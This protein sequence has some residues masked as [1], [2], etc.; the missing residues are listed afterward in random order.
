M[1]GKVIPI[2]KR[3]EHQKLADFL[4]SQQG[5]TMLKAHGLRRALGF[6][7]QR[8]N[9]KLPGYSIDIHHRG[10]KGIGTPIG[11]MRV[12]DGT[13]SVMHHLPNGRET[14]ELKQLAQMLAS[15]FHWEVQNLRN[16]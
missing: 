4:N 8:I 15:R 13:L 3:R 12:S 2:T 9:E 11:S 7:P 1:T 16:I 14:R 10:L 6:T 5:K